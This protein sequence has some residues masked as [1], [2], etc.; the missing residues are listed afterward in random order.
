MLRLFSA[1]LGFFW[2]IFL[3]SEKPP[4]FSTKRGA[5]RGFDPVCY[6]KVKRPKK[7]SA[8]YAYLYMGAIG[9]FVSAEKLSTFEANTSQYVA[10]FGRFCTFGM[11]S[12]Y[13]ADTQPDA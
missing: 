12:C 9:G 11:A 8:Y 1:V 6:F 3:R 10:Q 2:N 5:L 13:K 4:V 7:G